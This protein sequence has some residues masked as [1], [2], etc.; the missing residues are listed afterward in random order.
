MSVGGTLAL[1]ENDVTGGLNTQVSLT[2]ICSRATRDECQRVVLRAF[3]FFIFESSY[4]SSHHWHRR[5]WAEFKRAEMLLKA[6]EKSFFIKKFI[7]LLPHFVCVLSIVW[8]VSGK[9]LKMVS[10]NFLSSMAKIETGKK[11]K[12]EKSNSS[13]HTPEDWQ[14]SRE[15][16]NRAVWFLPLWVKV[17]NGNWEIDGRKFIF[18]SNIETGAL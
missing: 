1:L 4:E 8:A 16:E 10:R 6:K 15:R 14:C 3:V 13:R 5:L 18:D 9:V 12:R 17:I 2:A 11:K 7:F